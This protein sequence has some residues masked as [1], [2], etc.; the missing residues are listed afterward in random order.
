MDPYFTELGRMVLAQWKARDFDPA[1]F[2]SIAASALQTRPPSTEVDLSR[3]IADFLLDDEH[4]FQS[5]SDFGQPELIVYDHPRFYIQILFWLDGTTEIH[6][7]S[8]SGAFHVLEGSSI[9]SR[10]T[11]DDPRPISSHLLT[12]N[13]AWQNTRL[14]EKGCT[15][16][17]RAGADYIHALFHLE[18]PSAT[19]VVR[20]QTDAAS[21][22]QFTYLPP[23]LAIDPFA[24]DALTGRRK[25]LLDLLHSTADPKY[26]PLL[27]R[28][29]G[30][31]DFER[32]FF[33]LQS[34]MEHL[35]N[36]GEWEETWSVFSEKHRALAPSAERTLEDIVWRDALIGMR[37]SVSAVDHRFFLALLLNVPRRAELLNLVSQRFPGEPE[38]TVV[39]WVEE[40][41]DE[42]GPWLLDADFPLEVARPAKSRRDIF[43]AA[44]RHFLHDEKRPFSRAKKGHAISPTEMNHFRE[45]FRRSS[46]RALVL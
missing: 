45:A 30:E 16:E 11:F 2:P 41:S 3:L 1:L 33:I 40:L 35:R 12:G 44:L 21:G 37:G 4:P 9:H 42:S 14:L 32:G 26:L 7:H 5:Q 6:Q 19:V 39:G 8:F 25:Q 46:L 28:M 36:T 34:S 22:P 24:H 23:H 17:I 15:E 38:E 31:L 20:T 13:L 43:T 10:F 18:T 29:L 27:L